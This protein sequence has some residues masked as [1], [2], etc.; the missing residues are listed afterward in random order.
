MI[1]GGTVGFEG[2]VQVIVPDTCKDVNGNPIPVGNREQTVNKIV[3]EM[4]WTLDEEKYAGFLNA[5]KDIEALENTK[6]RLEEK[7]KAK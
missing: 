5:K 6:Q 3:D 2:H 7:L 1:E 4:L